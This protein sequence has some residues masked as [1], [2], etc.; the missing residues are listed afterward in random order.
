MFG[1]LPR[2][3]SIH[4]KHLPAAGTAQVQYCHLSCLS[5]SRDLWISLTKTN[6]KCSRML[7]AS[8][9]RPSVS[10]LKVKS[11]TLF[12]NTLIVDLTCIIS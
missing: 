1:H 12:V 11:E 9:G 2:Y 3:L 7:I 10:W 6:I 8:R 5:R 4:G